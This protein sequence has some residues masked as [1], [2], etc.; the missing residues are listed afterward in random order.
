MRITAVEL[1]AFDRTYAWVEVKGADNFK[2]VTLFSDKDIMSVR[3][4]DVTDKVCAVLDTLNPDA[5]AIPGW[6]ERGSLAALEWCRRKERPAIMMSASTAHD[7]R[8]KWWKEALK[9][10]IIGL[11]GAGLAGGRLQID[12]LAQLGMSREQ[13]FAGYDVVDNDYFSAGADAAR[14]HATDIRKRMGLPPRYFLASA[15]FVPKKNLACLIEAYS[16]YQRQTTGDAWHLVILGD[17]ELRP[18]LERQR[19]ALGLTDWIHMPGFK[20]YNELPHW[21]GSADTF[22]L[23]STTEQ[24]GLVVNEAMAAGLPVLVSNRC[25]CAPDLVGEGRN[26]FTFDPADRGALTKLMLNMSSGDYDL[27]AMG[28][29]SQRI[30]SRW[31]PSTFANGLLAATRLARE[32]LRQRA[33]MLDWAILRGLA[34]IS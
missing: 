3:V 23:S 10:R 25:G 34:V 7:E 19:E 6:S 11:C 26:G 27:A 24:W 12:Y 17:G 28:Q 5:V 33:S 30:I 20:Q 31:T 9:R 14:R 4:S 21:Y 2:R 18:D 8:R 15:R 13:I 32:S 29:E 1:S 16:S 22:V